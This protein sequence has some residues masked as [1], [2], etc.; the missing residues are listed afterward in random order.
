M[1]DSIKIIDDLIKIYGKNNSFLNFSTPFELLIAVMLSAQCTDKR[2]NM[3]TEKM[4]K[5]A[6]TPEAFSKMEVED[7]E[8]LI[9]SIS[10][11]HSKA[12]HIKECS[13]QIIEEF[14][15][16]VPEN[17]EDLMKLSGIG[18]KSANVIMLEAF[19]DC[20]GIAVDTHVFRI[21]KRLG[22][23]DKNEPKKVEQDLLKSF[24]K[25]YWPHVNHTLI[26]HGRE[27][28]KAMSPNCN[29]CTVSKYCKWYKSMLPKQSL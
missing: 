26:L 21:S 17:M 2:V 24:P 18:R 11:Y 9:N 14:D 29:E 5:I 1:K 20:Q 6:N 22:L 3:V 10:Y 8:K 16:T 4:F 7:I 27:I 19:N 13:K 25:E 23:S 28:C 12:K 15:G